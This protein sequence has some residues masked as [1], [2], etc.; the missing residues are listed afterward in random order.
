MRALVEC[1]DDV[2][3]DATS[4]EEVGPEVDSER[5]IDGFLWRLSPFSRCT[6]DAPPSL[7]AV[8]SPDLDFASLVFPF[9]ASAFSITARTSKSFS[10]SESEFESI[11]SSIWALGFFLASKF[12]GPFGRGDG[13]TGAIQGE[14]GSGAREGEA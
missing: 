13:N 1:D 12:G 6:F 8:D 3:D 7:F 4:A 14:T 2:G 11:S 9:S 5:D 10:K